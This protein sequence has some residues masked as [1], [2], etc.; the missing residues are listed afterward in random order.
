[1]IRDVVIVTGSRDWTDRA[2]IAWWLRYVQG[3]IDAAKPTLVHGAAKGADSI[4]A[5]E[6][7]RLGYVVISVPV[8]PDDGPWP[9]AGFA[10]NRRMVDAYVERAALGLAFSKQPRKFVHTVRRGGTV[11]CA[12]Y[13]L[14]RGIPTL[15]VVPAEMRAPS[16]WD[17]E[18]AEAREDESPR[19]DESGSGLV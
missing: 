1:M 17:A 6:G 13:M 8:K 3:F 11:D 2:E 10:R 15:V 14:Q 4:A 16:S 9:G 12:T 18:E 19:D 7:A 5:I